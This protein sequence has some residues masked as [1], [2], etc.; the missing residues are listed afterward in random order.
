VEGIKRMKE[1]EEKYNSGILADVMGLG[2]T[3]R[4]IT[5]FNY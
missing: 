4:L 5:N 1:I 2:K 3:S